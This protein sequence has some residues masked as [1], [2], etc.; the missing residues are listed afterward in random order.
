MSDDLKFELKLQQL[1]DAINRLELF[2]ARGWDVMVESTK[3]Q[4]EKLEAEIDKL[5]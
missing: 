3:K 5:N 2:K 1:D 4:I